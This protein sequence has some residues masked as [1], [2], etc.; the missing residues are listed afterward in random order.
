[1][2]ACRIYSMLI[3][4]LV[5]IAHL[6]SYT[7]LNANMLFII[8]LMLLTLPAFFLMLLHAREGYAHL[9]RTFLTGHTIAPCQS[10]EDIKYPTSLVL[11]HIPTALK[12]LPVLVSLYAFF[13]GLIYICLLASGSAELVNG[14]PYLTNH[15]SLI[16]EIT[17]EEYESLMRL[18]FRLFSMILLHFATL[19]WSFFSGAVQYGRKRHR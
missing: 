19:P 4:L 6:S 1:M 7:P 9:P 16:R 15:G 11:R 2:N 13:G 8:P 5:F 12:V 3:F 14:A 18:E 17:W 10:Y